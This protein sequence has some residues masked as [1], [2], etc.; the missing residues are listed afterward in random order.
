MTVGVLGIGS[1]TVATVEA[2][3]RA[4]YSIGIELTILIRKNLCSAVA[5]GVA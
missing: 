5:S 4:R 2:L 3:T 1:I